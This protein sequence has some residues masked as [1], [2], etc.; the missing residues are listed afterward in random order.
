MKFRFLE[1]FSFV[2]RY[3]GQSNLYQVQQ[4]LACS[5]ST[6]RKHLARKPHHNRRDFFL[7]FVVKFS[8]ST[9]SKHCFSRLKETA[10]FSYM[11]W[12]RVN[13][14]S[15]LNSHVKFSSNEVDVACCLHL[16]CKILMKHDRNCHLYIINKESNDFSRAIWNK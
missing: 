8:S 15:H 11:T 6:T 4:F 7:C 2:S 12:E 5:F 13:E 9:V 14:F 10:Q 1:D 16:S 3:F